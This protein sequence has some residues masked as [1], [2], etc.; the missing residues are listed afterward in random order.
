MYKSHL[1]KFIDLKKYIVT[2]SGSWDISYRG[3]FEAWQPV[4]PLLL[5]KMEGQKPTVTENLFSSV[6]EKA[7][8]H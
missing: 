1:S 5:D 8:L 3:I 7:A 2:F 4:L 6:S